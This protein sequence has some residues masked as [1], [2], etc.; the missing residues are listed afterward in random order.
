MGPATSSPP[1]PKRSPGAW[2]AT[3]AKQNLARRHTFYNTPQ[4]QARSRAQLDAAKA[5]VGIADAWRALDLPGEPRRSCCSPFREDRRPSFS[6]SADGRLWHDFADGTGGDVVSFVKTATG[7]NDRE[8]ICRVLDLAG[9]I[10]SSV[11]LAPR[12]GPAKP[13]A[14]PFDGLAGLDLKCPTVG[15]LAHL[16]DLRDWPT[17]AGLELAR[18]RGLLCCADVPHRGAVHR[19]WLLTDHDRRSAQARRLDGQ[20][21]ADKAHTYKSKSLRTD[22]DAP[23]GLADIIA[24]DRRAVLLCEGEPDALAALLLAWCAGLDDRMGVLCLAG[25]CKPLPPAVLEKLRGRRVRILRQ[26]DKPK[27][28]G[29][30]PS[31]LAALAWAESL[32]A[33]GIAVDLANLDGR[34]CAN[35]QP[36]KDI[37]DLCR[38]PADL[39][40]LE[41]LAA[42]ILGNLLP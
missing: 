20:P 36:A 7:C 17:F 22:H 26:S 38:R 39:E 41:Q 6:I 42:D 16:A 24:G 25:V 11:A 5:R 29:S 2:K 1:G 40:N 35:G 13:I 14:A 15:E 34:I 33:A 31:H 27:A 30:R 19:A 37:A 8:A 28:D 23:P 3:G 18:R 21:W 10:A 9:G 32:H 12:Q 4:T